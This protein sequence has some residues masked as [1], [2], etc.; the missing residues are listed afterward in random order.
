MSTNQIFQIESDGRLLPR[1]DDLTEEQLE[2][3]DLERHVVV[4]A[5]AGSGK[6][7]TLSRRVLRILGDFAWRTATDPEA[8]I[9]GPRNILVS[10]FTERA[11]AE[12]QERIREELLL[13]IRELERRADELEAH[14]DL[15]AGVAAS[16]LRILRAYHDNFGESRI[17]TFH[18]FCSASLREFSAE[19]GL[20]P[21]FTI[22][23][24]PEHIAAL[25]EVIES[26]LGSLEQA[27][28]GDPNMPKELLSAAGVLFRS[29][30]RRELIELLQGWLDRRGELRP[31]SLVLEAHSDDQLIERWARCYGRTQVQDLELGV[32]PGSLVQDLL[33]QICKASTSYTGPAE[34]KPP[35]FNVSCAA[36]QDLSDLHAPDLAARCQALRD[37]LS[38]FFTSSKGSSSKSLRKV[39]H[40]WLGSKKLFT[41]SEHAQLSALWSELRAALIELFGESGES[42][43]TLPG[44]ADASGLP[45]VR[46]LNTV[47]CEVVRSFQ[48]RK[49][50]KSQL[51]FA[52]LELDVLRLLR[53]HPR[54]RVRL[55]RRYEHLLIDEF[56]DTNAVQ[57]SIVKLLAGDPL[58]QR[59]LFLVGDPKQAIYRFRGGDVT[60]FDRAISEV[61][62]E[63][64]PSLNF[65]FNFRSREKL[66]RCFNEL[67]SWLMY[68]SAP[69]RPSWEAPFTKLKP[70]RKAED[71]E[72]P[73]I[74]EMLW[75]R[76]EASPAADADDS[77]ETQPAMELNPL[78]TAAMPLGREAALIAQRLRDEHL[79]NA[80]EHKG[81]KAAILLRRRAHLPAYAFALRQ[82]GI[83]HVIA[84]GRGFFA[85]QEVL[86]VAN[87]LLAL[88]TAEDGIALIGALRGPF[89]GLEDAWLLWLSTVGARSG[90][91]ALQ[92][93][94][95]NFLSGTIPEEQPELWD[96]LP[97]KGQ[98]EIEAAAMQFRRW[99]QL[100]KQLPLSAFLRELFRTSGAYHLFTINDPSGQ[101]LANI[102]KLQAL[103][104]SYDHR[105]AEGLADFALFLR[106]QE[107]AQSNEGDASIDATAPVV[108]MTIHQSKGLEFPIVVLPDLQQKISITDT[109][110]LGCCR[111]GQQ[112]DGDDLWELGLR[113]PVEEDQRQH[114]PMVLR[115]LIKERNRDEQL[116]ESRR[117]L[118]V[119]MTRARDRLICVSRPPSKAAS[120]P[121]GREDSKSWEEWLR[122]WLV[123]GGDALATVHTDLE[124]THPAESE[125]KVAP[126]T[127]RPSPR[128]RDIG[129]VTVVST[130]IL[131]PHALGTKEENASPKSKRGSDTG[132]RLGK[133]RGKLIHSCLED[134]LYEINRETTRRLS[135]SLALEGLLNDDN[136]A[137]L[138][139]ELTRHLEG[140]RAAAPVQL[141][142][143][144]QDNVFRELPFRI[145]LP[146]NQGWLKGVIDLLYCD[147]QRQCWVVLD[148]KSDRAELSTLADRYRA[149]LTAYAWAVSRVLPDLRA[150]D[151][152]VETQLLSTTHGGLQV[153][154]PAA[155]ASEL[156]GLFSAVLVAST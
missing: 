140:F 149:Q 115:T 51:D 48:E 63:E 103:A 93:G 60:L 155:T 148:Y 114:E 99:Q 79:P 7:R 119:A 62:T 156:A 21:G 145:A 20:D 97:T 28:Q 139:L 58:P 128:H 143:E 33:S 117:L 87:L 30:S 17:G 96:E 2:A 18:G 42:L 141:L 69:D 154:T 78:L 67:F 110:P 45:I 132:A 116:A 41:G 43:A 6:T 101:A 64:N 61:C 82:A 129:P 104:A 74:V 12:L 92:M 147:E 8:P 31:F 36:L 75:L 107:E 14:P 106:D 86:D 85:R 22:L 122:S 9:Q 77:N 138:Q 126:D 71:D 70:G 5:G 121:R 3:L 35:V 135:Q 1:G 68:G 4:T 83:A 57:W 130:R 98:L 133:L 26:S 29:F 76:G 124:P 136:L 84:K 105:G 38:P 25:D 153:V 95:K 89:L 47:A 142:A 40:T 72:G 108:L 118:Y 113:V 24:G 152:R 50:G 39:H 151:W 146:E 131:S 13:G 46:A 55:Q 11:A 120:P 90:Q 73:G 109:K 100:R 137:S 125:G 123:E 91:R 102:E 34:K 94:W 80:S 81:I 112:V 56:Q 127:D 66:I 88:S 150:P 144:D 27:E 44:R 23:Q 59:G 16:I 37:F 53:E 49:A 111:L 54:A 134:G 10:T 65:S 32:G 52:D 19:I 15:D